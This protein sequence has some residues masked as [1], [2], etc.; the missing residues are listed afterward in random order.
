MADGGSEPK[1]T[2]GAGDDVDVEVSSNPIRMGTGAAPTLADLE[3]A[4]EG[5][6]AQ[7]VTPA[8]VV[9]VMDGIYQRQWGLTA[10]VRTIFSH[11][12]IAPTNWHQGTVYF[13]AN[14]A[15]AA[16]AGVNG[17]GMFMWGCVMVWFQCV[18]VW[19]VLMGAVVPSCV[20]QDQC[21]QGTFCI[22]ICDWCGEEVPL[23]PETDVA[24]GEVYNDPD[25]ARFIGFNMTAVG[26]LC[27]NPR[28]A[29]S[30]DGAKM[31]VS[32]SKAEVISWC[33]G[34]IH[35]VTRTVEATS[36]ASHT[37]DT[38]AAMRLADCASPM[39]TLLPPLLLLPLLLSPLSLSLSLSLTC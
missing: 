2:A 30:T 20:T 24:T 9:R 27:E 25:D 35:P 23:M 19:A 15:D 5:L 37:S 29:E 4:L 39:A 33:D 36:W 22:G 32:Y 3:T 6:Q 38:V 21:R 12:T 18:T 11:L 1:G 26:E 16:D 7:T 28:P 17:R 13:L 10:T 14:P 8:E 31:S 34:C